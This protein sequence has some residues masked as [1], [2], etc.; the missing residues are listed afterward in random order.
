MLV[1]TLVIKCQP[2]LKILFINLL[3]DRKKTWLGG[4]NSKMTIQTLTIKPELYP[5]FNKVK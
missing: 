5:L 4:F 2:G 3:H 1:T